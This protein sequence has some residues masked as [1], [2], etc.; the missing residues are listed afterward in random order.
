MANSESKNLHSECGASA[1][2]CGRRQFY[3]PFRLRPSVIRLAAAFAISWFS[4]TLAVAQ[5]PEKIQLVGLRV[6][7]EENFKLGSWAPVAVVLRGGAEAA[8]GVVELTAPDADGV[9]VRYASSHVQLLPGRDTTVRLY[10]RFGRIDGDSQIAFRGDGK[11]LF[12]ARFDDAVFD[13]NIV[14]PSPL[15]VGSRL[16]VCIGRCP[17][18]IQAVSEMQ[19]GYGQ[20]LTAV[21]IDDL[22]E[23][24]DR[25]E[26]YDAV[27]AVVLA[28]DRLDRFAG[29]TAEAA[30][31]KALAAYL[32]RGGRIWTAVSVDALP[33]FQPK[34][35][36]AAFA[37]VRLGET[38]PLPRTDALEK[39]AG[40]GSKQ[41]LAPADLRRRPL[42][43]PRIAE[44][45]AVIVAAEGD[46]PLVVRRAVGLGVVVVSGFQTEHPLLASWNGRK[47]IAKQMLVQIGLLEERE[48]TAST[49]HNAAF[50]GYHDLAGQLR[51]ALDDYEGVE[52]VSY[53][54]L[55]L[56]I[57]G[58]L[59]LIGPIDYL[60]VRRVFKRPEMTWVTFPTIVV[61]TS[62]TAYF[63]A[64]RLK[65]NLVR[66]SQADVVD[67]DAATDTI[68]ASSWAGVFS[69][70]GREYD[71]RFETGESFIAP[72]GREPATSWFGLFGIGF[73]GMHAGGGG[74]WFGASY[75]SSTDGTALSG[76]PIQVWS[77]KSFVGRDVGPSVRKLHEPLRRDAGGRLRGRLKNPF[78]FELD[79]ALLCF[80]T[81]AYEIGKFAAGAEQD[82]ATFQARDLQSILQ[83]WYVVL[84]ANKNPTN[85]GRPHDPSSRN[86]GEIL[87]KMMFFEAAGS[88][89]HAN[90]HN[91]YQ[92][93][94]DLSELLRL[95]RAILVG[96]IAPQQLGKLR[97][98][99][100]GGETPRSDD[101][102]TSFVRLVIPIE[103]VKSE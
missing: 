14:Q 61:V 74:S 85:V 91:R 57:I 30:Q 37:P 82:L 45:D 26:G 47:A 25:V 96:Q 8:T 100:A 71:V 59:L 78:P 52:A 93:H 32:Q 13:Q 79:D 97:L 9:G 44:P 7:I 65:G 70:V 75:A 56:F 36:F 33:L 101:R 60:L 34:A 18:L 24:P 43:V 103:D 5:S 66:V 55:A 46:L 28:P 6:G 84:S 53:F 10:A 86:V 98:S 49:N 76:V 54:T 72:A 67:C 31:T 35:A 41:S 92:S 20:S 77:S 3:F 21:E 89:E 48:L 90:L 2:G 102:R 15:G 87:R 16:V 17:T 4:A 88:S 42:L 22:S 69:P 19:F 83:G 80:G 73:R 12:E 94:L 64:V 68:H 63:L 39:L 1:S 58:Y 29:W 11:T 81:R 40:A 99:V 62:L 51:S 38:V 23:L 27:D 95:N 50:Y